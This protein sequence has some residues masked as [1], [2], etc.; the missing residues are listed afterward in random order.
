[1][2]T[3]LRHGKRD[4]HCRVRRRCGGRRRR[5]FRL[6]LPP[7][8]ARCAICWKKGS[9]PFA[10][11]GVR[12]NT[13]RTKRIAP[14]IASLTVPGIRSETLLHSLSSEGVF[15]SSGSACSS[16]TG[17]ASST[18]L[19]FGPFQRGSRLPPYGFLSE[20]KTRKKTSTPSF[21][22]L[23]NSLCKLARVKR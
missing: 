7:H 23:K 2:G 5:I 8:E 4:R 14:H 12:I 20:R 10:A 1:M 11:F 21:P 9:P 18:L 19:S 16:H 17:H 6:S 15:V 13:P 3:A 22:R